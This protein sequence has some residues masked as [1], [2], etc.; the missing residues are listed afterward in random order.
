LNVSAKT[1]IELLNFE[2]HQPIQMFF[3]TGPDLHR[4][5]RDI[6]GGRIVAGATESGR[7]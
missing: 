2:H 1:F 3:A 4:G 7:Q 6:M 5:T